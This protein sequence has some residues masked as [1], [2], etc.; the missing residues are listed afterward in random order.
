MISKYIILSSAD[1]GKIATRY[2]VKKLALTH[3]RRKSPEML[4]NMLADIAR[5]YSGPV[6]PGTDLLEISV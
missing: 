4:A 3:I 5:D 6:V 2:A 1:A